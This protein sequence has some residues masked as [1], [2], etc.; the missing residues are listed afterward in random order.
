M[1]SLQIG[2]AAV[3]A[4]FKALSANFPGGTDEN[5]ER[6]SVRIAGLRAVNSIRNLCEDSWP[7]GCE[8]NPKPLEDSWPPGCEL[9]PKPLEEDFTRNSVSLV[10]LICC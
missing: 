9:N 1:S 3:V 2:F 6:T 4:R 10:K 5:E 7:P 8:L